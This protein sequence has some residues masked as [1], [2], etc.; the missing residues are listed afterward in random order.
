MGRAADEPARIVNALGPLVGDDRAIPMAT[1]LAWWPTLIT[2]LIDCGRL[3]EAAT[4]IGRLESA[5]HERGLDLTA[6]IT[7]ARASSAWPS[8]MPARRRPA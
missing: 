1:S 2:A 5:A 6:R 8:A 3:D 4:H 7:G